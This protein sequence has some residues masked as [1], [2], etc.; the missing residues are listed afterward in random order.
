MNQRTENE[1]NDIL[2]SIEHINRAEVSPYFNTKLN[3]RIQPTPN[4]DYS[5]R[6]VFILAV[7]LFLLLFNTYFLNSQYKTININQT[8]NQ[9]EISFNY[10]LNTTNYNYDIKEK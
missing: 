5:S 10:H 7:S 8:S 1:I 6:Y 2:N 4:H 3:G 9:D